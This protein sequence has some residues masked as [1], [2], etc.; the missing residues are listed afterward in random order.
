MFLKINSPFFS[1]QFRYLEIDGKPFI[2]PGI[3]NMDTT[4][5]K[6]EALRFYLEKEI[7]MSAFIDAYHMLVDVKN[8]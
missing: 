4:G 7:G 6:I 1:H 5:S 3:T 8:F 2:V